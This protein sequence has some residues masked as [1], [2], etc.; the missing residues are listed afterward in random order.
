MRLLMPCITAGLLAVA[1]LDAAASSGPAGTRAS[2]TLGGA[3]TLNTGCCTDPDVQNFGYHVDF[4]SW[5]D[6]EELATQLRGVGILMGRGISPST[7]ATMVLSD[8]SRGSGC[9][10]VLNGEPAFT[11]WEYLIFVSPTENKW[12]TVQRVGVDVGYCDRVNTT[13]LAAYD[14]D[15]NLLDF[16][17]NDQLGFQFLSVSRPSAD[18]ARIMVGDCDG[19]FCYPDQAGSALNCL[20]FSGPVAT[21]TDLPSNITMPA[22]PVVQ[23]TLPA[24]G[25]GGWALLGLVLSTMAALALRRRHPELTGAA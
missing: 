2:E 4:S 16:Q 5:P 15:G 24:L 23:G 6:G 20:S 3:S 11:G 10:Y 17:Y 19:P 25:P 22:P 12:A 7:P 14:V 8:P 1:V 9:T 18:I 13:F 21:T